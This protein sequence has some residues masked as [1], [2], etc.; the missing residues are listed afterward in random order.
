MIFGLKEV[1]LHVLCTQCQMQPHADETGREIGDCSV[2][3]RTESDFDCNQL[4]ASRPRT[5]SNLRCSDDDGVSRMAAK[6]TRVGQ[7]DQG[8]GVHIMGK[9]QALARSY[10]AL[11]YS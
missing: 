8:G 7:I 11:R 9:H 2:S 5:A 4:H 1:C 6:C 3:G 10:T